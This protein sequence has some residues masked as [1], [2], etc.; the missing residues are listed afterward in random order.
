M[1]ELKEFPTLIVGSVYCGLSLTHTTFSELHECVQWLCGHPV[2]THEFAH[3]EIQKVYKSAAIAQFPLLPSREDV[4]TDIM[5]AK[6]KLLLTYGETVQVEHGATERQK[7]PMET[8]RDL[9]PDAEVVIVN[10]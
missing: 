1:T 10:T 7:T 6:A 4:E 8:L 5:A 2:W 3:P 9:R